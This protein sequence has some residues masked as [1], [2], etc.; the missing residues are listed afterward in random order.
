MLYKITFFKGEIVKKRMVF[1]G[2]LVFIIVG[3][4]LLVACASSTKKFSATNDLH[5]A[6]P[7][8]SEQIIYFILTDRFYD[9]NPA[10]SNQKKGEY[11]PT[12]IAKY[13]GGDIAGVTEKLDYIS[14]LGATAV[15]IT[16]PVANQW[17]DPM[18]NYGGYHGYWAEN[19][20]K[21]D[22]HMGTLDEYKELSASLHRRGMYLIQDIVPNHMGNFFRFT[23]K[24]G[25]TKFER[26][27]KSVPVKAPTQ[28]PFNLVDWNNS[29]H[30]EAEIYHWTPNITNF[31]NDYN[32]HN[33]QLSDLDD[34]N[35]E[36]PQV[37]AALK[38]SYAY[39][40]KEVGV[41]GF[42][43]DTAKYVPIDFW[44]D[45]FHG[46]DG[47]IGQAKETGR[48]NFTAFG[49]AWFETVPYD[50]AFD[51]QIAAYMGREE[52]PG[53]PGMLNFP[54]YSEMI[55]VFAQGKATDRIQYRLTSLKKQ[56]KDLSKLY[57]FID[58]H[59]MDRFLSFASTQDLELSLLFMYTIPGV[60]IIYYGTEQE[61]MGVRDSMFAKGFGSGGKDHF[62]TDSYFYTYLAKLAQLR[63]SN[64]SFTRGEVEVFGTT[65]YGAGLL[66]YKT[67]YEGQTR[68]TLINTSPNKFLGGNLKTGI[69]NAKLTSIFAIREENESFTTN[70][71]GVFSVLLEPKSA[72]V[73]EVADEA[74]FAKEQVLLSPI[75]GP[76]D[77]WKSSR[78]VSGSA[79]GL[80]DARIAIDG[81]WQTA[82]PVSGSFEKLLNIDSLA[83]GTHRAELAG[84]DASGHLLVSEPYFFDVELNFQRVAFVE[85]PIGDDLGP[86]GIY[87][88]PTDETFDEK[89]CDIKSLEVLTAGS[90]IQLV[91]KMNSPIST[92]WGPQNGF[93]HVTF[94]IYFQMPDSTSEVNVMPKQNST[95]PDGMTWDY[96]SQIGGWINFYYSSKDADSDKPGTSM[97]PGPDISID[98]NAQT[99]TFTWSGDSFN[100]PPTVR[101]TKIYAATYDYDGMTS[102]NRL[103]SKEVGEWNFSGGDYETDPLIID[104]IG[105]IIIP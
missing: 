53:F 32:R 28:K 36:N 10:N 1:F 62:N 55:S 4:V 74:V 94:Y 34:L 83:A 95:L 25:V 60:P 71:E 81:N 73:L 65:E 2:A 19:L 31:D 101:G 82:T 66:A 77:V 14:G 49:E 98:K 92:S 91:F 69:P 89:Q 88:Y 33:N 54:L 41:D 102:A 97:V 78:T 87:Q 79:L 8:W 90:N 7:D 11:D 47:I 27:K 15:W 23:E 29:L 39:W 35:T 93:D 56:F 64:K 17:W 12:T 85:D 63:L 24:D 68:I 59:D 50:D 21:V 99:I 42:R 46:D 43:V 61:F 48:E 72:I 6:S 22:K 86:L 84:I 96:F 51:R 105:P 3:L 52:N 9:G 16:P 18:V 67:E 44:K 76:S 75:K 38:E 5:V 57:N 40:I 20:K 26:N 45:F 100:A 80:K 58:N 104:D 13:S 103:M 37:I 30:R 70:S